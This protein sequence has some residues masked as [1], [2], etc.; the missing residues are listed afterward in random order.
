M[1]TSLSTRIVLAFAA[2]LCGFGLLAAVLAKRVAV[3]HERETVQRLSWGL[4]RNIVE[5]WPE[6]TQPARD[7]FDRES[8]DRILQML[9]VV[10]PAID[11]YLL[12]ENGR[13]RAAI[14]DPEAVQDRQVDIEAVRAFL[15]GAPLPLLGTDPRAP[16]QRKVFSAAMFPPLP[17]NPEPPGYLY[18]VLDGEAQARAASGA[19]SH[20]LWETAALVAGAGM[21]LALAVGVI[22]VR[23]I[24]RPLRRLAADMS[25]F[26]P[27]SEP[28]ER[29]VP[30]PVVAGDEVA[31]IGRA[32]EAMARR[33]ERQ[34]REQREQQAAHNE[35]IANVAHDLRTPLT[36]LHGYLEALGQGGAAPDGAARPRY[37]AIALAQSDKVRNL[38]RQL[39]ELARLQST[40]EVFQRDRFRLDELLHDTV[41]KFELAAT[42]P[43][44]TIEGP[45]PGP[46]EMDGDL[47]LIDRAITNLIDNAIRHGPGARPVRVSLEHDGQ[48]VQVMVED[49]GP[50]LPRELSRRLDAGKPVR[51]PPLERKGGGFGGL[52]LAIAQRIAWLHGGS[53]RTLPSKG[54]GTRLCLSLPLSPAPRAHRG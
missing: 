40:D 41:Q 4:A 18:V 7:A 49:D 6:V 48:G 35:V 42:P 43:P 45:A 12:D 52:G 50:G 11:V 24:T 51:E 25:G 20:R 10:N 8:L 39:F 5:H 17:G 36:A 53:L 22:A 38:S 26:R 19:G 27:G 23:S 30:A 2:L 44:V 47:Q 3:E 16:G 15:G 28:H 46:L 21:V 29:P 32:F 37:L 54:G 13:V 9:M 31:A 33:I 1:N 14:G 34:V